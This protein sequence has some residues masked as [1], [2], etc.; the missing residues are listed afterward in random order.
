MEYLEA[1]GMFSQEL[2]PLAVLL[3]AA[4]IPHATWLCSGCCGARYQVMAKAFAALPAHAELI[5]RPKK[6]ATGAEK[7]DVMGWR[8]DFG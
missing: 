2:T 4:A 5:A 7:V 6:L 3:R 1:G 8:G